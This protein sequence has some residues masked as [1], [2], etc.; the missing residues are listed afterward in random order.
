MTAGANHAIWRDLKE[1]LVNRSPLQF[2]EGSTKRMVLLLAFLIGLTQL[3]MPTPASAG[4]TGPN[5]QLS[6]FGIRRNLHSTNYNSV[7]GYSQVICY[8]GGKVTFGVNTIRKVVLSKAGPVVDQN[9]CT[10]GV[11]CGINTFYD[12]HL[13]SSTNFDCYQLDG[14]WQYAAGT[15]G[16]AS[17]STQGCFP[18]F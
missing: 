9:V 5:C 12:D 10:G 13:A 11:Y 16:P 3:V 6:S 7:Q 2:V 18:P 8:N 1:T 17:A 15:V 14:D 4:Q